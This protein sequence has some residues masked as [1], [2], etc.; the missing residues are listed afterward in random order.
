MNTTCNLDLV[1]TSRIPQKKALFICENWTFYLNEKLL[2]T[3]SVKREVNQLK[4]MELQEE[5]DSLPNPN[6][7]ETIFEAED[8]RSQIS[9]LESQINMEL[10]TEYRSNYQCQL[11]DISQVRMRQ[12]YAESARKDSVWSVLYATWAV[13]NFGAEPTHCGQQFPRERVELRRF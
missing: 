4:V 3:L 13:L 5:L 8:I 1:Q 6:K 7:V 12:D 10:Q 9:K 11:S 2:I